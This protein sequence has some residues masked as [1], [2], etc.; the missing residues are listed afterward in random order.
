M[1]DKWNSVIFIQKT[2]ACVFTSPLFPGHLDSSVGKNL[3][4]IVVV[5]SVD[6]RTS[7]LKS[8]SS[9]QVGGL[10]TDYHVLI[11]HPRHARSAIHL[12]LILGHLT[13]LCICISAAHCSLHAGGN[14][15]SG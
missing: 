7:L 13:L 1:W 6:L 11:E 4:I 5:C 3:D 8:Y 2:K 9:Y 10:I 15:C 12:V 14:H